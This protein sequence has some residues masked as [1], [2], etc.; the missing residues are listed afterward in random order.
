MKFFRFKKQKS[1]TMVRMKNGNSDEVV[2]TGLGII[3]PVG[4]GYQQSWAALVQGQSGVGPITGFDASS[5]PVRIAG[6]VKGFVPG[7]FLTRDECRRAEPFIQYAIAASRLAMDDA[8]LAALPVPAERAAV[9]V[10][11]GLGGIK[12]IEEGAQRHLA[13]GKRLSPFFMPMIL[14]NMAAGNISIVFGTRGPCIS[15]STACSSGGTAVGEAS[16]MIRSGEADFAITG[17]SEAMVCRL[18][19][20][21]FASMRVLSRHNDTPEK[22]SRPFDGTRDGFVLSEGAAILVLEREDAAMARGAR[23]Y[24]R[25]RGYGTNSDGHHITAPEPTARFSAH[26]IKAALQDAGCAPGHIDYINAHGT[27]TRYNDFLEVEALKTALGEDAF[28]IPISSTKSVTGH[29]MGAAGAFEAV[30]CALSVYHDL[31]PPSINLRSTSLWPEEGAGDPMLVQQDQAPSPGAKPATTPTPPVSA[32]APVSVGGGGGDADGGDREG[33]LD[34]CCDS[35]MNY[36]RDVA[37]ATP[38][39]NAISNSFGFGGTNVCL[40]F[41]KHDQR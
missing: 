13:D 32:S 41:G 25:L 31:I 22:A 36:I 17:A 1:E 4:I 5:L 7:D 14:P 6:E 2:I 3:G 10:G 29:M 33:G 12:T 19:L 34:F 8:G 11:S 18:A 38:V 35:R 24:A 30:V 21:G 23:I 28:R 37:A 27:S 15:P 26:C 9:V 39:R 16:R 40:V 20:A